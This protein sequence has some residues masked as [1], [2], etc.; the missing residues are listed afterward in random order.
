MHVKPVLVN[1]EQCGVL[2][3]KKDNHGDRTWGADELVKS[4][5]VCYEM[6]KMRFFLPT[7]LLLTLHGRVKL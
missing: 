5:H 4:G 3:S 7:E 6:L 1:G 2:N